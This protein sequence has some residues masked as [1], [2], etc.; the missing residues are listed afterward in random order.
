[1]AKRSNAIHEAGILNIFEINLDIMVAT[2]NTHYGVASLKNRQ[3][4]II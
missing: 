3:P 4:R 1:V 2:K